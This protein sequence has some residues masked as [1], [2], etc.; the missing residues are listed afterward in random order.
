MA[1]VGTMARMASMASPLT[2]IE[3]D[4]RPPKSERVINH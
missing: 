1:R 2:A 3:W 4:S